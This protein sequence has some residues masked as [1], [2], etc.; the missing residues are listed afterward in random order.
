MM[1]SWIRGW[2]ITWQVRRS[3]TNEEWAILTKRPLDPDDFVEVER[4]S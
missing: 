3:L 4:P 1:F 2:W